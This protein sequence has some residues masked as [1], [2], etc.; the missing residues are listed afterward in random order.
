MSPAQTKVLEEMEKK[1]RE[2][3]TDFFKQIIST[4][5]KVTLRYQAPEAKTDDSFNIQ[6]FISSFEH[7]LTSF[8]QVTQRIKQ[9]KQIAELQ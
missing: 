7:S 2:A 8:T 5:G 9:D 6:E 1:A 3:L 4:D